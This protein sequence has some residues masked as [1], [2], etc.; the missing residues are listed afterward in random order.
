MDETSTPFLCQQSTS[1]ISPLN[2]QILGMESFLDSFSKKYFLIIFLNI[3]LIIFPNIFYELITNFNENK[4][5][6]H[7]NGIPSIKFVNQFKDQNVTLKI[8]AIDNNPIKSRVEGDWYLDL[9]VDLGV[10]FRGKLGNVPVVF[11]DL[12]D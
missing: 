5:T 9:G 3:F 2:I 6:S 4:P 12:I 8:L 1:Q 10:G 7:N 11:H